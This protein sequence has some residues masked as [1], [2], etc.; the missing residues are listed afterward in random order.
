MSR[1]KVDAA[2]LRNEASRMRT[3]SYRIDDMANRAA[4]VARDSKGHSIHYE[5][6]GN[7]KAL[8]GELRQE[9]QKL[10]T[11][12]TALEKTAR[13]YENAENRVV[14]NLNWKSFADRVSSV[15]GEV[16]DAY[17]AATCEADL[18]EGILDGAE[19][20]E[21]PKMPKKV[22]NIIVGL[23]AATIVGDFGEDWKEQ[24]DSG[25]AGYS[26]GA[27]A[28][29]HAVLGIVVSEGTSAVCGAAG[30]FAGGAVGA[31]IGGPAGAAVGSVAGA[32][33]GA[34]VGKI[35]GTVIAPKVTEAVTKVTDKGYDCYEQ[36][37]IDMKGNV[38]C[39][40]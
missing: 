19:I 22:S 2:A 8:T 12:A 31:A 21:L 32:V 17:S 13:T 39:K 3:V 10:R 23:N 30:K 5:Y 16:S 15:Y 24:M 11:L 34:H 36:N 7:V 20:N 26:A 27:K 37:Y 6:G 18:I 9:A 29:E 1:L 38:P 40:M 35:V 4:K 14:S 33:V 25:E 28:A